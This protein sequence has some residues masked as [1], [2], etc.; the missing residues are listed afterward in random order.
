MQELRRAIYGTIKK[1]KLWLTLLIVFAMLSISPWYI[2]RL[3]IVRPTLK[4][5]PPLSLIEVGGNQFWI[6]GQHAVFV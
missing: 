2:K 3:P 5:P 6:G 4:N 1:F